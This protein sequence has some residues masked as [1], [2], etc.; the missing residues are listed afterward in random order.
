MSSAAAAAVLA[1][2]HLTE[3]FSP[4]YGD[5]DMAVQKD[6]CLVL[7]TGRTIGV[8]LTESCMMVPVKSVTA[9]VGLF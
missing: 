9:I 2:A 3:R 4:G 5:L 6:L 1:P 7:D 8:T